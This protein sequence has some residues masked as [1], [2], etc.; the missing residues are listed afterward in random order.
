[1]E[2]GAFVEF[3]MLDTV[4][5]FGMNSQNGCYLAAARDDVSARRN[6]ELWLLHDQAMLLQPPV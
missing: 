1:M 3:P 5:A 4:I 2:C 6:W